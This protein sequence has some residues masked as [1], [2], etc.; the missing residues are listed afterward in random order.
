[1]HTV[2]YAFSLTAEQ[3][4]DQR[5]KQ[6]NPNNAF[7]DGRS[8]NFVVISILNIRFVGNQHII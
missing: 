2:E 1:M 7:E 3:I 5:T 6:L 8:N 4:Q